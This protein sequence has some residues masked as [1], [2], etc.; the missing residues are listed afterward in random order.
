MGKTDT[1]HD[2]IDMA[3]AFGMSANTTDSNKEQ[4][5]KSH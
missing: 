3:K 1:R 2:N 4:W 5:I